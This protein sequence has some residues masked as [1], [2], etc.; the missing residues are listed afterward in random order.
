MVIMLYDADRELISKTGFCT[1]SLFLYMILDMFCV[2]PELNTKT[3]V[4]SGTMDVV[5]TLDSGGEIILQLQ[6]LLNDDDRK[7]I[8]EMV[9]QFL[10]G[11]RHENSRCK[12]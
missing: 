12:S 7:R 8:Q 9:S 3:I 1:G 10:L 2:L 6:F 11:F 5:F 4:E